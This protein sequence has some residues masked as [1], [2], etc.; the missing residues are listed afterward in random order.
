MVGIGAVAGMFSDALSSIFGTSGSQSGAQSKAV[1]GNGD[2]MAEFSKQTQQKTANMISALDKNGDGTLSADEMGL[3]PQT[4]AAI[5]TNGDGQL[6]ANELNAAAVKQEITTSTQN[7]INK[8]DTNGDG[9]LTAA[10]LNMS[11]SDFAAIDTTGSGAVGL[12]QLMAASPLNSLL[13]QFTSTASSLTTA[14]SAAN[15]V[16]ALNMIA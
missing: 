16:Q 7:L 14:P 9:K 3:P 15:S 5:D 8:Y 13:A 4:F 2:F 10:E 11:A 12:Q 6:D 1:S